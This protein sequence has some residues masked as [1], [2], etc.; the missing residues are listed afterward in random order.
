[1]DFVVTKK[2]GHGEIHHKTFFRSLKLELISVKFLKK[3]FLANW[4]SKATLAT[5]LTTRQNSQSI[6]HE[7]DMT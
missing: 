6:T 5:P 3:Q 7:V 1:M 4:K 2:L